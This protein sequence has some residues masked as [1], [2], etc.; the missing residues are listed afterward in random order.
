M[1]T[2][3]GFIINVPK[4][5]IKDMLVPVICRHCNKAYDL[6]AVHSLS[7]FVDCDVYK[8]PCCGI[9]ADTREYKSYPDFRKIERI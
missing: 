1:L 2:I 4:E 9:L 6:A 8:T 7:R 5:E 3:D